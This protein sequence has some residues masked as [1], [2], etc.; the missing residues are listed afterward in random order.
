[1]K[2]LRYLVRAR[3]FVGKYHMAQE[4][5]NIPWAHSLVEVLRQER[6]V[7]HRALPSTLLSLHAVAHR[8]SANALLLQSVVTYRR[9][10]VYRGSMRE[11]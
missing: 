7:G 1:M 9:S 10:G 6:E 2:A 5:F 3:C 4:G 8:D 11:L